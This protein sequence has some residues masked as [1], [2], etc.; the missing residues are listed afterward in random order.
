MKNKRIFLTVF[1]LFLLTFSL[2][3]YSR[4]QTDLKEEKQSTRIDQLHQ[5]IIELVVS[6]SDTIT[7]Q[8]EIVTEYNEI[9]DPQKG[10]DT[11]LDFSANLKG[12]SDEQGQVYAAPEVGLDFSYPLFNSGNRLD[13]LEDKFSF[14]TA[15]SRKIS[16][17][18]QT[19][20]EVINSLNDQLNE[21]IELINQIQGQ[22]N[23]LDKLRDRSEDLTKM[24]DKGAAE[25]ESL[26]DLD[27][28][29]NEIEIENKNLHSR[30]LLLVN[31]I[32]T[33]FGRD[34]KSE[35]KDKLKQII[36]FLKD[37]DINGS[38]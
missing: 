12:G 8:Q 1:I 2:S 37:G 15:R 14:F 16:D 34:N 22:K 33:N 23:L 5:E 35:L 17:L 10:K 25:P 19:E 30:Q 28:R 18:E 9:K 13:E 21:L 32:A 24:V 38:S 31:E 27:E 3:F 36:D 4:A 20:K 6:S 29:I 7:A 11:S 26:W